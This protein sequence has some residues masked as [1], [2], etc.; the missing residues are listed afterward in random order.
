MYHPTKTAKR[1]GNNQEPLVK[2]QACITQVFYQNGIP[3]TVRQQDQHHVLLRAANMLLAEL[4]A[5]ARQATALLEN[6][7]NGSVLHVQ[8]GSGEGENHC[9][10]A[11]GHAASQPST[12][13]LAGFN[14]ECIDALTAGY[15]LGNGYR[16]YMPALR[17]FNAPDSWSPF[18]A[19]GINTYAYCGCDP[20]NRDDPSGHVIGFKTRTHGYRTQFRPSLVRARSPIKINVPREMALHDDHLLDKVLDYLPD[21]ALNNLSKADPALEP[22]IAKRSSRNLDVF[23][24]S[25]QFED[26]ASVIENPGLGIRKEEARERVHS[27][28]MKNQ[29]PELTAYLNLF[30]PAANTLS[31]GTSR[32]R[33]PSQ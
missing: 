14:G 30:N 20:V 10:T 25:P 9:F 23:M 13:T 31:R 33:D 32:I 1:R 12:R 11:Y 27:Q 6:D 3:V 16:L 26:L 21:G 19:G 7:H 24:A 28:I 8:P 5:G 15:L 29:N 4:A 2:A 18:D 22:W 17:R